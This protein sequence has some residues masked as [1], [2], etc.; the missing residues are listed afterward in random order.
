M[1]EKTKLKPWMIGLAALVLIP[2]V[3]VAV[4]RF[5]ATFI[6]TGVGAQLAIN[7]NVVPASS[8]VGQVGIT[9]L[10]W[11][12]FNGNFFF[13]PGG[14]AFDADPS[15]AGTVNFCNTYGTACVFG[16]A[17]RSNTINGNTTLAALT[18]GT[19]TATG[20][21]PVTLFSDTTVTASVTIGETDGSTYTLP[22]NTL[23]SNGM[24]LRLYAAWQHAA[25]AN[26]TTAKLYVNGTAILN[27]SNSTSGDAVSTEFRV[28]R[29][30][31]T[32]ASFSG[33]SLNPNGAYVGS[34]GTVTIAAGS[35]MIIK[36]SVTGA[37]TNGD[38]STTFL[39]VE[40]WPN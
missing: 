18:A 36:I 31:A 1:R 17:G 3:A 29:T 32:T 16:Q 7:G 27:T 34:R 26:A 25:N 4:P 23:S 11:N 33:V 14:G 24:A 39:R 21:A 6:D 15:S 28:I 19:G 38:L 37:T 35:T 10:V 20:K 9:G 8:G 5:L 13:V 22:A 40:W 2:G 12:R 30:S